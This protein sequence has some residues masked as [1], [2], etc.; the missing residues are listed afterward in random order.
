[1]PQLFEVPGWSVPEPPKGNSNVDKGS[2]KRKRPSSGDTN[3]KLLS[4]EFNFDK[5][6]EKLKETTKP[7]QTESDGQEASSRTAVGKKAKKNLDK[8][9]GPR[10]EKGPQKR[11]EDKGKGK[12]VD[13]AAEVS[14]KREISLPMPLQ[15]T[16]KAARRKEKAK[17]KAIEKARQS[18]NPQQVEESPRPAKRAKI[19][20]AVDD[21]SEKRP[22]KGEKLT[23]LQKSMKQSLDGAKFR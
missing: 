4:A 7:S 11:K 6:M 9:P 14:L 13:A 10:M 2:K 18:P 19:A 23:P 16:G 21:R 1:M 20:N 12:K 8:S 5:L 22:V 3:N 15:A 17:A